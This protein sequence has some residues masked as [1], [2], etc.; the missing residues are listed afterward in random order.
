LRERKRERERE[1]ERE[2]Y[3]MIQ[4]TGWNVA[5]LRLYLIKIPY[6]LLFYLHLLTVEPKGQDFL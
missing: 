1:R 3:K 5:I 6:E 2:I 4:N